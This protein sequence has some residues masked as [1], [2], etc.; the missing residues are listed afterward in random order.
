MLERSEFDDVIVT[1]AHPWG[2]G[3]TSLAQWAATG[4]DA[5][6][7]LV[8]ISAAH[9]QS[10]GE[11]VPLDEIPLEY[12]NT[13]RSRRLQR[14]GLLP[15]PWGPPPDDPPLPD[16]PPDTPPAIREILENE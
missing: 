4:P 15:T 9:R 6:R 12:H 13:R 11:A 1:V 7:P 10:T 2:N 14:E 16:L 8:R 5:A 3:H